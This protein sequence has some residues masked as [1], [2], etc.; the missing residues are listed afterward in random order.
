[1]NDEENTNYR[2]VYEMDRVDY[3]NEELRKS[4][5]YTNL[6]GYKRIIEKYREQD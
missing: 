2:F 3:W 5:G 6:A 1:M 4:D